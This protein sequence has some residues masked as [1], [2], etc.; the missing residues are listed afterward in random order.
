MDELRTKTS[1]TTDTAIT[2]I[3]DKRQRGVSSKYGIIKIRSNNT[4]RERKRHDKR[5]TTP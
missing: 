4:Q 5:K 2:S 1:A 3:I